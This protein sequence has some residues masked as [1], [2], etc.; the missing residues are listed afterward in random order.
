[1]TKPEKFDEF[2]DEEYDENP[3][4]SRVIHMILDEMYEKAEP[5]MDYRQALR[6]GERGDGKPRYLLHYLDEET[7]KEI[8]KK[9]TEDLREWKASKVSIGVHLG[10][11]PTTKKE[12]VN[13]ERREAGLKPVGDSD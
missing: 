5:G 10:A 2:V 4:I 7:Q 12:L 6:D 1:M 11:A 13:E 8:L 3:E 9:H